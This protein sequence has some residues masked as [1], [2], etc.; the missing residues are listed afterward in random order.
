MP[1]MTRDQKLAAKLR[2]QQGS[3]YQSASDRARKASGG[4]P[5]DT[6]RATPDSQRRRASAKSPKALAGWRK[7]VSPEWN[8]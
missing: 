2:A 5:Y 3:A 8:R 1:K 6:V 7:T 4:D